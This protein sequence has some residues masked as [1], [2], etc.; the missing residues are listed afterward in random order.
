[1]AC[2]AGQV[3]GWQAEAGSARATVGHLEGMDSRPFGTRCLS[4]KTRR[5][6]TRTR[7]ICFMV[8]GIYAAGHCTSTAAVLPAISKPMAPPRRQFL[9]VL[10]FSMAGSTGTA[11]AASDVQAGWSSSEVINV[12]DPAMMAIAE[13]ARD[14]TRFS[15]AMAKAIRQRVEGNKG[16][17]VLEIGTG[18][19]ALFALVA[20]R[21]GAK[22]V[23]ALEANPATA[24]AA[25]EVVD[26][27]N[28]IEEG[29][30]QIIP[31]Y[32]TAVK[33]P[34][35]VDLVIA[36]LVGGIASEENILLAIKDAQRRHLKDPGNPRSYIPAGITTYVAPVSFALHSTV[37][38]PPRYDELKGQP[39]RIGCQDRIVQLQ[40]EP[41]VFESFKLSDAALPSASS[42]KPKQSPFR[43]KV[44]EERLLASK[45]S[46]SEVLRKEGLAEPE[47]TE[48]AQATAAG[49]SGLAFWPRLLLD[50][51]GANVVDSRGPT[52][53][54]AKSH[55]PTLLSLMTP[56]PKQVA[57]GD[58]IDIEAAVDFPADVVTP[59]TYKLMGSIKKP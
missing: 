6:S 42:W 14:D 28:D 33:L 46:Y 55:W 35:K 10:G 5:C 4:T 3:A 19:F 23:Y 54:E 21:A 15:V 25:A 59:V 8:L 9:Q 32:S 11:H 41:Q 17:T 43:F 48:T 56:V 16:L 30:I 38:A 36:P 22:K 50:D 53:E 18:P 13:E 7:W 45:E 57:A 29:Q 20:A 1:M 47:R 26:D 44:S 40:A 24:K 12:Q 27:S 39:L 37:L 2:H 51:S 34:E 31:G 52:G 58:V 49:F